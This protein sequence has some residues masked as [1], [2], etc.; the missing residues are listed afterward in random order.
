MHI[1]EKDNNTR[2]KLIEQCAVFGVIC[3]DI[4][5]SVSQLL[6]QGLIALQHRG[7]E[8]AGISILQ[9]GGKIFT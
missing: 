1:K 3:D 2:D 6:Y 7:Q 9:T 4:S 5:Y 8:S